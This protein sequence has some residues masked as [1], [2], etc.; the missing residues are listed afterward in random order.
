[1][2][3]RRTVRVDGDLPGG[4]GRGAASTAVETGSAT[5]RLA[6]LLGHSR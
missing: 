5:E 4:P 1:M 2:F 6:H 3:V